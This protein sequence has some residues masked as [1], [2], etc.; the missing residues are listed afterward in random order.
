MVVCYEIISFFFFYII[1]FNSYFFSFYKIGFI[2]VFRIFFE[3][4]IFEKINC[5][6]IG[7]FI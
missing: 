7:Y 1:L 6:F 5:D 3:I 4:W 2:L